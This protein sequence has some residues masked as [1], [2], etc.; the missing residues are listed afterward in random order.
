[1]ILAERLIIFW[2]KRA[3]WKVV[4]YRG[5]SSINRYNSMMLRQQSA[6]R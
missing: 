5:F 3:K 6:L 4:L 1:M 2:I